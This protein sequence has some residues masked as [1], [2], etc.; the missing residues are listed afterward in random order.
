[1]FS[2]LIGAV[3]LINNS[4]FN[5]STKFGRDAVLCTLKIIEYGATTYLAPIS[6]QRDCFE[7]MAPN[8]SQS[9]IYGP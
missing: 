5:K 3:K 1:M 9:L 6:R 7:V 4:L 2:S 8:M